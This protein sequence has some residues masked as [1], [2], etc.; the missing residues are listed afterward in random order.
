MHLLAFVIE[1]VLFAA[2]FQVNRAPGSI[3]KQ[4]VGDD[5]IVVRRGSSKSDRKLPP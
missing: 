2:G 4:D 5:W 1:D 3:G